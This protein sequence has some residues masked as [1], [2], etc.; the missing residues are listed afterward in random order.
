MT[1]YLL[2]CFRGV[3][4]LPHWSAALDICICASFL[5]WFPDGKLPLAG[6]K[7]LLMPFPH[8]WAWVCMRISGGLVYRNKSTGGGPYGWVLPCRHLFV[9]SYGCLRRP[10]FAWCIGPGFLGGFFPVLFD[11]FPPLAPPPR[12]LFGL[13]F[14]PRSPDVDDV[15]S[16]MSSSSS[17]W[18]VSASMYILLCSESGQE[19]FDCGYV[20][21]FLESVQ[22]ICFEATVLSSHGTH[23]QWRDSRISSK[24]LNSLCFTLTEFFM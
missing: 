6:W 24:Y 21:S 9:E 4:G 11:V 8:P 3:Q 18:A 22:K 10:L 7:G 5:S 20:D 12:P 13:P 14:D 2:D 15:C 17:S 23:T 1:L 19:F 16:W